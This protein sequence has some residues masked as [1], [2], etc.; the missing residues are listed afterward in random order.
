MPAN[1]EIHTTSPGSRL[2]YLELLIACILDFGITQWA[3][4]QD[5]VDDNRIPVHGNKNRVLGKGKRFQNE[6]KDDLLEFF[7][8]IKQFAQPH[9]TIFVREEAG[10]GLRDGDEEVLD[11]PSSWFKRWLYQ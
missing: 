11:L 2:M 1:Q 9:S 4:Y 5:A 6:V 7:E 8:E 10:I 3:T